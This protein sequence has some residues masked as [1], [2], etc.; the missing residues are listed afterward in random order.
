MFDD[1]TGRASMAYAYVTG[2]PGSGRAHGQFVGEVKT[3]TGG[4]VGTGGIYNLR[5][6]KPL[7][8]A[9]GAEGIALALPVRSEPDKWYWQ[10]RD[11]CG[12]GKPA[13][14]AEFL[15]GLE[16]GEWRKWITPDSNNTE[17]C[18]Q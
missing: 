1:E 11:G 10:F 18:S 4:M 6:I 7:R 5:P 16:A 15:G 12:D 17:E 9:S 8:V 14:E 2:K 13:T 3:L